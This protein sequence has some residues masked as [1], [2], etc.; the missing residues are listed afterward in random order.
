[1]LAASA[2]CRTLL[3]EVDGR[4]RSSTIGGGGGVGS[5]TLAKRR[6][7]GSAGI[8]HPSVSSL[9]ERAVP[10]PLLVT[11]FGLFPG[12]VRTNASKGRGEGSTGGSTRVAG[13]VLTPI[14]GGAESGA[15]GER[16][17]VLWGAVFS[18]C[19]KWTVWRSRGSGCRSSLRRRRGRHAVVRP[20]P[21]GVN[22]ERTTTPRVE[23]RHRTTSRL[24]A[25]GLVLTPFGSGNGCDHGADRRRPA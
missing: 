11:R 18:G 19:P 9:E 21:G 7:T 15:P 20:Q 3:R 6:S 25:P 8:W 5:L 24:A 14:P 4:Y 12:S 17:W 10:T 22:Q 13:L 23:V 16:L 2:G 1:M